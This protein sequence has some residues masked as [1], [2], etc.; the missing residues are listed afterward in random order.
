MACGLRCHGG[1]ANPFLLGMSRLQVE[2]PAL[3]SSEGVPGAAVGEGAAKDAE[4]RAIP[5][6]AVKLTESEKSRLRAERF[7]LPVSKDSA[8]AGRDGK[9]GRAPIAGLGQFDLKEEL[10]RRK[11]RAERF[12]MP[13]PTTADEV[14]H[15]CLC[16]EG[17]GGR[18]E[19]ATAGEGRVG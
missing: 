16:A 6:P 11:K 3:A 8:G 18:G 5:A 17:E 19:D 7:G 13:V 15:S 2:A 14:R 1:T 10:D 4:S 12:G 9:D